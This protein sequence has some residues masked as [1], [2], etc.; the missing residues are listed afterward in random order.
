MY[1]DI[2]ASIESIGEFNSYIG[3]ENIWEFADFIDKR[4]SWDK[5]RYA[6]YLKPFVNDRGE[7]VLPF[8]REEDRIIYTNLG[9]D[10]ELNNLFIK[11][12]KEEYFMGEKSLNHTMI[13][14]MMNL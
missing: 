14:V 8:A 3:K 7:T 13:E 2:K 10:K 9:V 4:K 11:A 6:I 1:D 5:G 12:E